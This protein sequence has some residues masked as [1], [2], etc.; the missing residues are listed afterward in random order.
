MYFNKYIWKNF[1][2]IRAVAGLLS[3]IGQKVAIEYFKIL[4]NVEQS[5]KVF[6]IELKEEL[7]K[8]INKIYES[9]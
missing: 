8:N 2:L 6:T 5:K 9:F 3:V 4:S 7:W 1:N